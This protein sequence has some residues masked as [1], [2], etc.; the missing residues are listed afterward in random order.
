[1][2]SFD[3]WKI[4]TTF[5]N[6]IRAYVYPEQVHYQSVISMFTRGGTITQEFYPFSTSINAYGVYVTSVLGSPGP[7]TIS[8]I[9]GSNTMN[10]GTV[11]GTVG[12]NI[13]NCSCEDI[14]SSRY[15]SLVVEASVNADNNYNL[16]GDPNNDYFFNGSASTIPIAFT[17][18]V[19]DFVYRAYNDE[20]IKQNNLPVI[21]VD[22]T[23]RP[24][25]RDRYLSGDYTWLDITVRADVYGKHSNEVDKLIY[26][27][28]RGTYKNRKSFDEIYYVTPSVISQKDY[29]RPEVLHR[30]VSWVAKQLIA[31]E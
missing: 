24:R 2:V 21:V 6:S 20:L 25:V 10:S 30:S 28:D 31:R 3:L 13:I 11:A 1:M 26:G 8:C 9:C 12:W 17:V 18:G 29:V 16:G 14:V 23:G 5:M 27:A 19:K 7:M 4:Q 22:V 15:S